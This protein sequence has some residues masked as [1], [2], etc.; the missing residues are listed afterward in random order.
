MNWFVQ[1]KSHGGWVPVLYSQR[2]P[3]KVGIDGLRIVRTA[4]IGAKIKSEP[5]K[6]KSED[7]KKSLTSLNRIYG[8]HDDGAE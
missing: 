7:R 6:V 8:S 1:E 3:T 5:L 2:P 4:G